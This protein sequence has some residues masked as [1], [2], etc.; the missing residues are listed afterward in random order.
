MHALPVPGY[1]TSALC[2]W[3][4]ASQDEKAGGLGLGR[5][6]YR[7]SHYLLITHASL[8]LSNVGVGRENSRG[9]ALYPMLLWNLPAPTKPM[10]PVPMTALALHAAL[11]E[12]KLS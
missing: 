11:R 12:T 2:A 4:A 10:L 1:S 9:A 6:C 8:L 3:T 5:L 7:E